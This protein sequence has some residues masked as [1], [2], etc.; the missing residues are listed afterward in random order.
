MLRSAPLLHSGP[1]SARPERR[2]R[3]ARLIL[4]S[5]LL[6]LDFLWVPALR[7]RV[8]D[9]APRPGHEMCAELWPSVRRWRDSGRGL[10]GGLRGAADDHG[11]KPM[12]PQPPGGLF[13]VVQRHRVD[14][15]VAL[16][17]VV[18]R[19]LVELVLQQ[20]RGQLR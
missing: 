18:D 9:V 11:K 7:C 12:S 13:D 6:L 14:D 8:K 15:G 3:G 20:R 2:L 4:G 16:L 10:S 5:T 1:R 17:D 19:K